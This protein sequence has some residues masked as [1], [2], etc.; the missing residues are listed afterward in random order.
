MEMRGMTVIGKMDEWPAWQRW[1][2]LLFAWV[3]YLGGFW[4]LF[5]SHNLALRGL[6]LVVLGAGLV[7]LAHASKAVLNERVRSV[8]R[9]QLRT[10]LPALLVYLLLALYVLPRVDQITTP[11]LKAIAALSPMLPL[12]FIAWAMVRYVNRCDEMER[13]QHLEAAGVAVLVVSLVGMSLGLLAAA[14]LMAVS[15][16]MVLLAVFPALCMVYGLA[17]VWSKWRNCAR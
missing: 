11:W 10:M 5:A 6:A 14:K 7:L 16:T 12:L 9:W 3:L 8:D 4:L 2:A 17:C 1:T 15:G 13:R